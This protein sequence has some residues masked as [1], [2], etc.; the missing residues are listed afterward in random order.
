MS[1]LVTDNSYQTLHA[2]KLLIFHYER[3]HIALYMYVAATCTCTLL[4]VYNTH[5]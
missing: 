1:S 4:T 2:Y 5:Q 3:G